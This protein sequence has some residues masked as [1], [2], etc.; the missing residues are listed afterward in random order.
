M[1]T[2]TFFDVLVD[3]NFI[4]ISIVTESLPH[5][6]FHGLSVGVSSPSFT[7][8][9]KSSLG[10]FGGCELAALLGACED[11]PEAPDEPTDSVVPPEA[12]DDAD[13][14]LLDACEE[15]PDAPDVALLGVVA[16]ET[17]DD[18]VALAPDDAEVAPLG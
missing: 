8:C 10:D 15:A 18:P 16:P 9:S 7:G 12:P 13:V 1:K 3:T 11:A 14:A 4:S 17:P 5:S 2:Q 6:Y